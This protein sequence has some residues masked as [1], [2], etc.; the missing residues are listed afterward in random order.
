MK[1]GVAPC[2]SDYMALAT[3]CTDVQITKKQIRAVKKTAQKVAGGN[4]KPL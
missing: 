3:A 1:P 2:K 4:K